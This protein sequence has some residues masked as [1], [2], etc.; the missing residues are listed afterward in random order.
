MSGL[1]FSHITH[2]A[3]EGITLLVTDLP[4]GRWEVEYEDEC[5]RGWRIIEQYGEHDAL[6]MFWQGDDAEMLLRES[7][8]Q[9]TAIWSAWLIGTLPTQEMV[10]ELSIRVI[11][12]AQ[13]LEALNEWDA[14]QYECDILAEE[15]VFTE[16]WR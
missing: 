11:E 3:L 10:V 5:G 12:R 7:L 1:H 13:R 9:D 4:G 8:E 14:E 16:G 15:R 2:N 6:C